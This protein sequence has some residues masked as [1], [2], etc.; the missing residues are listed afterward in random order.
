MVSPTTGPAV[1]TRDRAD[2]YWSFCH[3]RLSVW[4]GERCDDRDAK[5]TPLKICSLL[6]SGTEIV[7]ALGLGDQVVSVRNRD[8][9]MMYDCHGCPVA[10]R[11]PVSSRQGWSNLPAVVRHGV[12]SLRENISDPNLC[13]PAPLNELVD[14]FNHYD[15]CQPQ[16]RFGGSVN[17]DFYESEWDSSPP[18]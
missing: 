6:P 9:Y 17:D 18:A 3:R 5:G 7:F 16:G 10:L 14:I 4:G 15:V 2:P 1:F 12:V 11:H 13:F 8:I